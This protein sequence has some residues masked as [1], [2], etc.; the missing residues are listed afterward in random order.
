MAADGQ[1]TLLNLAA[2]ALGDDL[3]GFH[4]AEEFELRL[5]ELLYFV[6]ASSAMLGDALTQIE[7]YSSI[8]NEGMVLTHEVGTDLTV[9][10][11]YTGV[12][13]HTDRHQME[14][15]MTALVRIC[16]H[17]TASNLRPIRI[18]VA[19]PRCTASAQLEEYLGCGIAFAAGRDEIAFGRGAA[20]L[21]LSGADPYLNKVLLRTC[22]E[23]LSRRITPASP[24]QVSVENVIAALLPDGRARVGEVA[25]ALG[26]SRRTLARRLAEENLTFTDILDRMRTDLAR[27]YLKDSGLSI[28]QV[29]WLLGFQEVSAFTSAFK[30]WTGITP[31]Q[32][33]PQR[34][35]GAIVPTTAAHGS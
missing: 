7:R 23:V 10:F 1:I 33:R 27:H 2:D 19:H 14:F 21:R 24:L 15:W 8:A 29:A 3:L 28:S 13:R 5:V 32:M 17:L 4:L 20:R 12:S 11:S 31:S 35:V 9:R 34:D 22:E 18:S 26:M 6:L 30:R 25:R 16:R